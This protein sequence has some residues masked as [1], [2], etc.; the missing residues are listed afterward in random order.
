MHIMDGIRTP[1]QTY[2]PD[3]PSFQNCGTISIEFWWKRRT[4]VNVLCLS[5]GL[6]LSD[7]MLRY[8]QGISKSHGQVPGTFTTRIQNILYW[9]GNRVLVEQSGGSHILP[10]KTYFGD[11]KIGLTLYKICSQES[12]ICIVSKSKLTVSSDDNIWSLSSPATYLKVQS[13]IAWL[14][15]A[16]GCQSKAKRQWEYCCWGLESR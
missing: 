9:W 16:K 6:L 13:S 7:L 2:T 12:I 11:D 15:C 3:L 14:Y 8:V 4:T 10:T 1:V 5:I